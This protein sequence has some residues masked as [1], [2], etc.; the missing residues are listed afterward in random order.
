MASRNSKAYIYVIDRDFGFAPNPFHGI[1]TLACCKPRLRSTAQAGDWIFGVGGARLSATG[2]CIYGMRV[3][4][5][6]TFDQYWADARFRLKRPVRNGSRAMMLGD[7]IYHRDDDD[8][9][10]QQED[11][12]HSNPDGST[13]SSNVNADTG[14]NRV[15]ISSHFCYFGGNAP[16]VPAAI[17]DGMGYVNGRNHRKFDLQ[18]SE[19][20]ISWFSVAARGSVGSMLGDPFQFRQSA[21]RYS[22]GSNRIITEHVEPITLLL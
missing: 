4:E 1:C 20:L 21:A 16:E 15:L 9:D 8:A 7:N 10:W 19:E 17:F 13:N 3:E 18:D 2:R 5:A 6:L 22:A 12:H 14:T 11:S